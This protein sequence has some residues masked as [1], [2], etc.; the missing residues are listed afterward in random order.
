MRTWVR[1]DYISAPSNTKKLAGEETF[2]DL[3]SKLQLDDISIFE[4]SRIPFELILERKPEVADVEHMLA[5]PGDQRADI[6]FP[7]SAKVE[8][9]LRIYLTRSGVDLLASSTQTY[10]LIK[11]PT[12]SGAPDVFGSGVDAYSYAFRMAPVTS[13]S[14]CDLTHPSVAA[15]IQHLEDSMPASFLMEWRDSDDGVPVW[16]PKK[17]GQQAKTVIAGQRMSDFLLQVVDV[18]GAPSAMHRHRWTMLAN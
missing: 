3:E 8:D 12:S 14:T 17:S 15:A 4:W 6:L 9:A 1:L 2:R 7:P 13:L 16:E 10:Y 11:L 18:K 5:A